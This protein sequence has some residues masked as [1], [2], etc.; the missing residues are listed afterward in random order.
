MRKTFSAPSASRSPASAF[1]MIVS[2]MEVTGA[3]MAAACGMQAGDT[4][5]LATPAKAATA[6]SLFMVCGVRE[7][8]CGE[9]VGRGT[10]AVR[11]RRASGRT[12][13]GRG[14]VQ[15]WSGQ[16]AGWRGG[17]VRGCEVCGWGRARRVGLQ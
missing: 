6:M 8:G 17:V 2:S 9:R 15:R 12:A 16:P 5:A 3:R 4:Y 13:Q 10:R 7:S 11:E 1:W 14:G